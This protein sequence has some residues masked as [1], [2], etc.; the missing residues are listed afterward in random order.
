MA[1]FGILASLAHLAAVCGNLQMAA[2]MLTG[3]WQEF[4]GGS[5]HARDG[6]KHLKKN[7][8]LRL[9]KQVWLKEVEGTNLLIEQ[10]S[11]TLRLL[12][13]ERGSEYTAFLS[14]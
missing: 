9:L 1:V 10:L 7:D 11:E 5:A 6:D 4:H 2:R 3:I 13:G 14:A 8:G 12:R